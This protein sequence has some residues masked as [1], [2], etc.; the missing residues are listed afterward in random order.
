MYVEVTAKVTHISRLRTVKFLDFDMAR[1]CA[2]IFEETN[3]T[4]AHQLPAAPHSFLVHSEKGT[5]PPALS[6]HRV[7]A[8][9]LS[10]AALLA[11]GHSS[12]V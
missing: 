5:S 6:A 4:A 1:S 11:V 12:T 10:V 3:A 9:V 7:R 8:T 2:D